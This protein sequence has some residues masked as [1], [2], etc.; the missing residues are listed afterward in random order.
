M[1]LETIIA[2]LRT[3]CPTFA[4]NVAGAAQFKHLD[5]A[6]NL[7]LPCA[8]VI[9]LDDNPQESRSMNDV[10]QPMT[11]SFAVIVALSN[12]VD[13]KGQASAATVH[14]I[15][16]EIWKALLGWQP[17]PR[18]SGIEY[19]GGSSLSVDRAR[20]W[21]QFEFGALMEIG[22]ADGWQDIYAATLPHF[23]GATI[24]VDI[25]DPA[26]DPNLATTGPDGRIEHQV[27]IPKTGNLA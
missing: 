3:Y 22:Q 17:D 15:R 2:H 7:P 14:T 8:F 1:Q 9:P 6:T 21:Y 24:N 20:L 11:E 10:L 16:A 23:D 5:S 26:F 19:E 18:Y 27:V 12:V 4:Q 25:I 13:E